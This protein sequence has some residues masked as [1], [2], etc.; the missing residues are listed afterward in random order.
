MKYLTHPPLHLQRVGNNEK[1]MEGVTLKNWKEKFDQ[2]FMTDDG[3]FCYVANDV[4]GTTVKK[5][6]ENLIKMK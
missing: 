6:I 5:F 4:E 1:C 3:D 2:Y